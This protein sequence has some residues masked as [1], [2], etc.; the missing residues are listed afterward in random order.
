MT[1]EEAEWIRAGY[2]AF[3]RELVEEM[4]RHPG[5]P[6]DERDIEMI[7]DYVNAIRAKGREGLRI[8][9]Y[10]PGYRVGVDK[11]IWI[12]GAPNILRWIRD[13]KF[14][15]KMHEI[16]AESVRIGML[17]KIDELTGET[18]AQRMIVTAPPEY[19]QITS[20]DDLP[21]AKMPETPPSWLPRFP[22][23]GN[24]GYDRV[25]MNCLLHCSE[26]KAH[27]T[28]DQML[29]DNSAKKRKSEDK[30]AEDARKRE[31]R[32]EREA[33]GDAASE[34]LRLYWQ[35]KEAGVL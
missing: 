24:E 33:G 26:G 10:E 27:A 28:I 29:R 3:R 23:T 15:P 18:A 30:A 17:S 9:H 8:A 22:S 1:T 14:R 2:V 21:K 16:H 5:A 35:Q 25:I 11:I 4:G 12:N 34:M 6:L 19:K 31:V 13:Q 32:K 20:L 7:A